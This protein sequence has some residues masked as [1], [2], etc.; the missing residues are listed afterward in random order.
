MIKKFLKIYLI[1]NINL[2]ELANKKLF[3][4]IFFKNAINRINKKK[5]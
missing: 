4:I 5:F 2:F 3:K 1:K